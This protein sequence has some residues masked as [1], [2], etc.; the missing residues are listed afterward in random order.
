MLLPSASTSV[1]DLVSFIPV[2]S[3]WLRVG[4]ATKDLDCFSVAISEAILLAKDAD[5]DL[6]ILDIGGGFTSKNFAQAACRLRQEI[7]GAQEMFPN[8]QAIAEPGRFLACPAFTL[9]C[10]VL[11]KRGEKECTPPRLYL[12]DGIFGNFI[13]AFFEKQEFQ[14]C[15]VIRG[16]AVKQQSTSGPYE[17]SLWGPTCDSSD[18]IA[19]NAKFDQTVETGDWLVFADMGAYTS[20]CQTGFNGFD[21]HVDVVY[22]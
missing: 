4:T 5:I 20:V 7:T 1:G 3:I 18:R 11:G 22:V 10:Q 2:C 13:N 14:P 15:Y 12:N 21:T 19:T 6:R 8:L 16:N 17:Y 9:A